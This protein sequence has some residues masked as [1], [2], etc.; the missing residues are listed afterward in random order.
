[1]KKILFLTYI[2]PFQS[3]GSA[4]RSR[5]LIRALART[6][7]VKVVVINFC[8]RSE[9]P[10]PVMERDLDGVAVTEIFIPVRLPFGGPRFDLPSGYVTDRVKEHVDFTDFD[11]IV[12]RYVKPALK[13][14]LPPS[15]PVVVDFDDAV[16][17]PPWTVLKTP[18]MKLG[19]LI[20]LLNDRLIVRFRL[21]RQRL[22]HVH[23]FFC[24]EQERGAFPGLPSSV[25]PNIPSRPALPPPSIPEGTATP[26]LV[27]IGLLDYLPNQE[28]IDWFLRSAWPEV[29]RQV[30]SA[31][32]RIV[33][34]GAQS[35]HQAW[36]EAG[37]VDVLG[38]VESLADAYAPCAAAIVPMKGGAG[39]NIKALEAY[40]YGRPVVATLQVANAYDELFENG[41]DILASDDPREFAAACVALLRDPGRA[42]SMA[43]AGSARIEQKLGEAHFNAC[44]E[45]VVARCLSGHLETIEQITSP[46]R[47]SP[48]MRPKDSP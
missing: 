41:R 3:W 13:L 9:T 14:K 33:G 12:S 47:T 6:A 31:R 34:S 32:L 5:F 21:A 36:R 18:K 2:S 43:Q 46:R 38:Y 26:T 16:F 42:K 37:G 29:R 27:F 28:A 15:V 17:Q 23:Y 20:R 7:S 39:T 35:R 8:G 40:V 30:P 11:L 22:H 19:A 4:Q 10:Q 44:V 1:M 48:P 25:L 45:S 24:R